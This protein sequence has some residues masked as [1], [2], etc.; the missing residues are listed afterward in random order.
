VNLYHDDFSGKTRLKSYRQSR[1]ICHRSVQGF[2][3]LEVLVALVVLAVGVTLTMSL[4]SGSLGNIWKVHSRTNIIEQAQSVMELALLDEAI[5]GPI[6]FTGDFEDGTRW[7]VIV[8]EYVPPG[9]GPYESGISQQ[10]MPV[11]LLHYTVDMFRP[12][13]GST[14]LRLQTLKLI[15]TSG[16]NA[17]LGLSP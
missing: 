6:T 5:Q 4:I 3:L 17:P 10:D 14:E 11:R 12:N 15:S 9:P 8:E 7:Q 16:T 1:A 2:T 13:S